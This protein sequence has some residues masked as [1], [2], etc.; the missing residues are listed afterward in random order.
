[1]A[2]FAMP[3]QY[4]SNLARMPSSGDET[5]EDPD[6]PGLA[7]QRYYFPLPS[8]VPPDLAVGFPAT[9]GKD[10]LA[11]PGQTSSLE[12]P[13]VT[14]EHRSF[15]GHYDVYPCWNQ[16][17]AAV[18][19]GAWSPMVGFTRMRYRLS[20]AGDPSLIGAD[21]MPAPAM[22]GST[23]TLYRVPPKGNKSAEIF[24]GFTGAMGNMA[25][26]AKHMELQH[27]DAPRI[28]DKAW[29]KFQSLNAEGQGTIDISELA[30]WASRIAPRSVH[31]LKPLLILMQGL[32]QHLCG[33][34][35]TAYSG[36]VL[37]L[38]ATVAKMSIQINALRGQ[39]EEALTEIEKAQARETA[40][41]VVSLLARSV[42]RAKEGEVEQQKAKLT[43]L[44]SSIVAG[45]DDE[46][47]MKIELLQRE[48][49]EVRFEYENSKKKANDLAA[50]LTALKK[51]NTELEQETEGF[52]ETLEKSINENPVL[53]S[54]EEL[55]RAQHIMTLETNDTSLVPEERI[56]KEAELKIINEQVEGIQSAGGLA[57]LL[58]AHRAEI[59]KARLPLAANENLN[60]LV[61][62]QDVSQ[63]RH[64][65]LVMGSRTSTIVPAGTTVTF[66][67][68]APKD[69]LGYL[70]LATLPANAKI[71]FARGERKVALPPKSKVAHPQHDR[72]RILIPPN[73]LLDFHENCVVDVPADS[74]CHG[75]ATNLDGDVTFESGKALPGGELRIHSGSQI[76]LPRGTPGERFA[77]SLPNGTEV[78]LYEVDS[79]NDVELSDEG[80]AIFPDG[81]S[82]ELYHPV[83]V[84]ESASED[85][86]ER[87]LMGDAAEEAGDHLAN[88]RLTTGLVKCLLPDDVQIAV[89]RAGQRMFDIEIPVGCS[90]Q[91][92][93]AEEGAASPYKNED[94]R[95]VFGP[96]DANGTALTCVVPPGTKLTAPPDAGST[97]MLKEG[98][99][100]ELPLFPAVD[101]YVHVPPGTSITYPI[102]KPKDANE[103]ALSFMSAGAA[104]TAACM[105]ADG[106]ALG[107]DP[108]LTASA[109]SQLPSA[110]MRHILEEMDPTSA[111]NALALLKPEDATIAIENLPTDLLGMQLGLLSM[112]NEDAANNLLGMVPDQRR[113]NAT[114]D[115]MKVVKVAMDYVRRMKAGESIDPKDLATVIEDLPGQCIAH[116]VQGIPGISA[117]ETIGSLA[118]SGH[119]LAAEQ[120]M[121]D[122]GKISSHARELRPIQ[123]QIRSHEFQKLPT[124]AENSDM[125]VSKEMREAA[126][127]AATHHPSLNLLFKADT[128]EEVDR[129]AADAIDGMLARHG[130]RMSLL[131][132]DG[133]EEEE[134][135][136]SSPRKSARDSSEKPIITEESAA[137]HIQ[138]QFRGMKE[139]AKFLER[140]KSGDLPGQKRE[141]GADASHLAA[142]DPRKDSPKKKKE[143]EEEE[144]DGA[145]EAG[146]GY[147]K[148]LVDMVHTTEAMDMQYGTPESIEE[149]ENLMAES[150]ALM[151]PMRSASGLMVV[152]IFLPGKTKLIGYCMGRNCFGQCPFCSQKMTDDVLYSAIL[153]RVAA[154]YGAAYLRIEEMEGEME[155]AVAEAIKDGQTP[156]P[157]SKRLRKIYKDIYRRHQ[158][159]LAQRLNKDKLRNLLAEI[160][161]YPKPTEN[162]VRVMVS[163]LV[164]IGDCGKIQS[165][166]GKKLDSFPTPYTELWAATRASLDLSMRSPKYLVKQMKTFATMGAPVAEKNFKG[167]KTIMSDITHKDAKKAS[168]AIA[169]VRTYVRA[170]L[171]NY[172]LSQMKI[173]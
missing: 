116:V 92:P 96:I 77:C 135:E 85:K 57:D 130:I 43:E 86:H 72:V 148:L 53:R 44:E 6:A 36:E 171:Q 24:P 69:M 159:R 139:R 109:L 118:N 119:K 61:G 27:A 18:D 111:G 30:D 147:Q 45:A 29:E 127:V 31:D 165:H 129:L 94:E 126:A 103:L 64:L 71:E 17:D 52:S 82:Y 73:S 74:I 133:D 161:R 80:Y 79:V 167:A 15:Y 110:Y 1:M 9:E 144:E 16:Y 81:G 107:G 25:E 63:K 93:R 3:S 162:V 137:L 168:Q 121:S 76:I 156:K 120:A 22:P 56:K 125:A 42:R 143:Q 114:S 102:N 155:K 88:E 123:E 151:A 60:D 150:A 132:T 2:R 128:M 65:G 152:P 100:L 10:L 142:D 141:G 84:E 41:K 95:A 66:P 90:A 58:K 4:L 136:E 55:K 54:V 91:L 170:I 5:T 164:A 51:K 134:D 113:K 12:H 145:E 104:S 160:K 105:D 108:E 106:H 146:K 163:L 115:I 11:A 101:T 138:K 78:T 154:A 75:E 28:G 70:P 32:L 46:L 33:N 97:A 35:L 173:S 131:V 112:S 89:P 48:L 19:T 47:K 67:A 49:K 40:S 98:E 117:I 8:E 166:I 39:A 37:E 7:F 21:G 50:E 87:K 140:K 68:D 34:M 172:E 83:G 149:V 26:A 153:Q 157:K 13:A 59:L 158:I 20:T 14:P 38:K 99:T 122:L 62:I 23:R 124:I 169:V